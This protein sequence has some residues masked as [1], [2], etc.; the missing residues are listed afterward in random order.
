MMPYKV[1]IN[2]ANIWSEPKFN[3]ERIS[4][5]LFNES[6]DILENG[7]EFSKVRLSDNYE[8][9]IRNKFISDAAE[10]GDGNE[11]MVSATIAIGY[12]G[13]DERAPSATM[14]PFTSIIKAARR[15]NNFIVC[16]TP[17]FGDIYLVQEDLIPVTQTPKVIR[18][19]TRT[20]L[21]SARRFIGVPYLWGGKSFFGIDCSGFAQVNFKFFGIDL[22]RDTKDQVKVGKEIE[23]KDI[24]PGDLLFF[25]GHVAIA[26]NDLTY[27]HSSAST[28][29]VYINSFDRSAD[30][31]LEH[32]DKGL[33]AVRRVI[34]D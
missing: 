23:R 17:R 14:L 7:E 4:Q 20:F 27:I 18:K 16:E 1:N 22:P 3:S 8:G 28:G 26:I 15:A 19:D 13:A 2:V 25:K 29:G 9:Y 30:N 32:L 31:Y 34:E 11:F 10:S 6:V 12:I 21:E 5:A 33:L 24:L